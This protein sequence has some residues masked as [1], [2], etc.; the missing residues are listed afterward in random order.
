MDPIMAPSKM[1]KK[2]I[3]ADGVFILICLCI[4]PP[5]LGNLTYNNLIDNYMDLNL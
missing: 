5:P 4:F 3:K 2:A 1:Q